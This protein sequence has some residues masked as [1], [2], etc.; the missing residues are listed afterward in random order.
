MEDRLTIPSLLYPG[1]ALLLVKMVSALFPPKPE[2]EP[3]L[4]GVSRS[5]WQI[6]RVKRGDFLRVRNDAAERIAQARRERLDRG[7]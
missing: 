6:A 3:R 2:V 5:E 4:E 7:R 1:E